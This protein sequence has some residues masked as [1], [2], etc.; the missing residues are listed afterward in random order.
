MLRGQIVRTLSAEHGL[1]HPYAIALDQLPS[2]EMLVGTPIGVQR[3]NGRDFSLLQTPPVRGGWNRFTSM[4]SCNGDTAFA[5]IRSESEGRKAEIYRAIMLSPGTRDTLVAFRVRTGASVDGMALPR[6]WKSL[7]AVGHAG[8]AAVWAS[9]ES[10]R[11]S[12]LLHERGSW[13]VMFTAQVG[14]RGV[15]LH[16]GKGVGAFIGLF[17]P[18]SDGEL[19]V[20]SGW[21]HAS[22]GTVQF[23]ALKRPVLVPGNYA[24]YFA[25]RQV[26]DCMANGSFSMVF[27]EKGWRSKFGV[28]GAEVR[29]RLTAGVNWGDAR[30]LTDP[31]VQEHWAVFNGQIKV[32][33]A[34]F[35]VI[36]TLD[37]PAKP[38]RRGLPMSMLAETFST[39]GNLWVAGYDGLANV[40]RT[41]AGFHHADHLG[42]EGSEQREVTNFPLSVR[43]LAEFEGSIY[44]SF[45]FNGV[46]SFPLG[47]PGD[48]IRCE[49]AGLASASGFSAL[50]SAPGGALVGAGKGRLFELGGDR[51][52]SVLELP[53]LHVAWELMVPTERCAVVFGVDRALAVDRMTGEWEVLDGPDGWA[54]PSYHTEAVGAH[55]WSSGERGMVRWRVRPDSLGLEGEVIPWTNS[56]E[57]SPTVHGFLPAD[58]GWMWLA[59]AS[60]GLVKWHPERGSKVAFPLTGSGLGLCEMYEIQRDG[61][62]KLWISSNIG[63]ICFSPSTEAFRIYS[64]QDGVFEPEFNRTS[65][66]AGSDGRLYFG[67]INGLTWFD[68]LHVDPF[69]ERKSPKLSLTLCQKHTDKS[70]G[71]VDLWDLWAAGETLVMDSEDHLLE[72]HFQ[73]VDFDGRPHLYRHRLD[74]GEWVVS[75]VSS[76][77]YSGF[78]LGE[79]EIEVQEDGGVAL[80]SD[81]LKV[82]VRAERAWYERPVFAWGVGL[83][84]VLVVV[85]AGL[86]RRRHLRLR[87]RQLEDSVAERTLELRRSLA[88]KE[89]YLKEIHHRVKNNLQVVE[90]LMDLEA[91]KL[92]DPAA[93]QA[94]SVSRG[95]MHSITLIHSHLYRDENAETILFSAFAEQL[96]QLVRRS[97]GRGHGSSGMEWQGG[98]VAM[99]LAS[100]VPLGLIVNELMTNSFKHNAAMER[101]ELTMTLKER[102]EGAYEMTYRDS[103][104]T[105]AIPNSVETGQSVGWRLILRL[106]DQLNGQVSQTGPWIHIRFLNERARKSIA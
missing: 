37:V 95:R 63:L 83:G 75:P 19:S 57:S 79:H 41:F 61:L 68:P 67:T 59:T 28:D 81:G 69:S 85:A 2:G 64:G 8:K 21:L 54:S 70:R 51:D 65:S 31:K 23:H 33:D 66:C 7:L 97:F 11:E 32:L 102:G 46:L 92:T 45:G 87:A 29:S 1:M 86:V 76:V 13:R 25:H 17:E 90:S 14:S 72:L 20:L 60:E 104:A 80:W 38:G 82:R 58:S 3:F 27:P 91:G 4:A 6:A 98:A 9:D 73:A 74:G 103:G 36:E 99:D 34:D 16:A 77:M 47:S 71:A 39:D 89:V 15:L 100:A 96:F 49:E 24:P 5:V 105:F 94:F 40:R 48:M 42:G 62:G 44:A 30:L 56:G 88:L 106:V 12:L 84:A 10:G 43:D 52:G 93:L 35:R 101:L 78:S 18:G 53:E 50:A 26:F 22:N 55:W